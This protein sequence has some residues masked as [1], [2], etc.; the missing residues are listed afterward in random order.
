M[1]SMNVCNMWVVL[2]AVFI[3][4][5][6]HNLI[7]GLLCSVLWHSMHSREQNSLWE[8]CQYPMNPNDFGL[9]TPILASLRIFHYELW[10]VEVENFVSWL[11]CCSE[12]M[13]DRTWIEY[14]STFLQSQDKAGITWPL[15]AFHSRVNCLQLWGLYQYL[16]AWNTK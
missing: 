14:V 3:M 5:E 7:E 4:M 8:V 16:S 10:Y 2:H 15:K 13:S 1:L 6:R 11:S 12:R 9:S